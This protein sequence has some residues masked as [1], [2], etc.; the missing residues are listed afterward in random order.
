MF[1]DFLRSNDYCR[2]DSTIS[3]F[4]KAR[5]TYVFGFNVAKDVKTITK[6]ITKSF[7]NNGHVLV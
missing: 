1:A 4:D 5:N 2:E 3:F 6:N 7:I